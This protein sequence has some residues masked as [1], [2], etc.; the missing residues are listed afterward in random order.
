MASEPASTAT[1]VAAESA[2]SFGAT[3]LEIE[4]EKLSIG[5]AVCVQ[6]FVNANLNCPSLPPSL[7]EIQVPG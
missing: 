5:D 2:V 6:L 7:P 3:G 1:P 4:L